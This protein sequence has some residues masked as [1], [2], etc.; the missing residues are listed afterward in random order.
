[1]EDIVIEKIE[2]S[3]LEYKHKEKS[4]DFIWTI[5]LVAF[6]VFIVAL[7][8]KN[9]LF[10]IFCIVGG[11]SLILFSIREPEEAY[12]SIETEGLTMGKDKYPWKKIKGFDIK[13][14]EDEDV[15]LVELD[16]HFLP[17]H[18]L[19]LP[20]DKTSL[21]KETLQKVTKRIELE[22]SKSMQFAEKIGL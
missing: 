6:V 14:K 10:G 20:K 22:E 7:W 11:A 13:K 9:Y 19:P 16:K 12:Y 1:M 5:G 2:W 15:L 4:V 8:M 18:S 17:I 3:A 21:V